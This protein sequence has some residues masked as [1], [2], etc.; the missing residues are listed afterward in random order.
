MCLY[1]TGNM[2][3]RGWSFITPERITGM[4]GS[5]LIIPCR[6]TYSVS[7]PS[8]LRVIWY[9]LQSNQY[10]PV[11]DQRQSVISKFRGKTSVIGSVS[12]GNCSL[13][14]NSLEMSHHKDRL[15]PWIDVNP[16][17]SYHTQGFSFS[18]KTSEIIVSGD[19]LNTWICY[20]ET[21]VRNYTEVLSLHL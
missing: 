8:D 1:L 12:G 21:L 19:Y 16:I 11:F 3:S 15:Y 6:F 7:Q 5:C 10:P 18:D 17:T 2:L 20:S 9:L 13:K 4:K 14:I